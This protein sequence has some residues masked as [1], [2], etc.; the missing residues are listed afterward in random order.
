MNQ[1]L[2]ASFVPNTTVF[3]ILFASFFLK[4]ILISVKLLQLCPLVQDPRILH[5]IHRIL[6]SRIK[7]RS[8]KLLLFFLRFVIDEL[9]QRFSFC[10]QLF[11]AK[12]PI[13]FSN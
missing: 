1:W 11:I 4:A 10:A 12:A 9:Y 3:F 13:Y 8:L 7:L 5:E 6:A 2:F